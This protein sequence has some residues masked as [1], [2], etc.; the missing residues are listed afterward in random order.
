MKREKG[1]AAFDQYYAHI[2]GKNWE[3]LSVELQKKR[4][5][6]LRFN[7]AD[8]TTL[9]KLWLEA[10]LSWNTLDW[11][12]TALKW[13]TEATFGETLP[14]YNQRLLY[15]MSESSL[16]PVAALNLDKADTVLDACA[17]PGGK[18]MA[19][20][21]T[22]END[23]NLVANDMSRDRFF[24]MQRLF[25]EY[26]KNPQ[27][28]VSPAEKISRKLP[29][30]YNKILLDAPCSSE[31]HVYS[32]KKHL[33]RWSKK[34][35]EKLSHRQYIL[36]KSLL[37]LLQPGGRLVYSTCALTPEEN[38][39]VVNKICLEMPEYTL[40]PLK[41]LHLKN[42][43]GFNLPE[44]VRVMPH[45]HNLEPMFVAAFTHK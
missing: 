27:R 18:A 42:A 13:P 7:A 14:G 38:E 34:R 33:D 25:T 8:E 20:L 43:Q 23:Q 44:S 5:P 30:S 26:G 4:L 12:P 40:V 28:T 17:A 31:T 32:S 15:P 10:G 29:L 9:R 6:I 39:I 19:I 3:L 41:L 2:F 35:I 1:K 37:P 21:D 24:R 11:Y 45:T 22:L 16:I 36:I